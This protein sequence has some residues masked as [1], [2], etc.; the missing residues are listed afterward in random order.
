MT[1]IEDRKPL[2]LVKYATKD[3]Q[4]FFDSLL[5]RLKVEYGDEYN[6]FVTTS[7]GIMLIDLMSYGLSH[8]AWYMDRR[9]SDNY[10]ATARTREA[11]E[12]LTEQIGYKMQ[13]AAASSTDLK[14]VFE[15]GIPADGVMSAGF[16]FAGPNNLIFETTA[17]LLLS[18]S[19]TSVTYYVSV[20]QGVTR[21]LTYTSNGEANQSYTLGS[22]PSDKFL[23][24][25]SVRCWID[26]EEW[27]EVNFLEY[28][29]T[30]Q[31][32]VSYQAVPPIVRFGDGV[33]GNIPPEDSEI[34]LQFVVI[35]GQAGNVKSE[36]ITSA[37]DTL[38]ILGEEVS[39]TVTNEDGSGGGT[40]PESA[41]KARTFAPFSFAAR[42]AA[43]T[44]SD[45]YALSSTFNS[46]QYGRVS[47][48]YAN[49][50]RNAEDDEYLK[51][52]TGVIETLLSNY[53][54]TIE[55]EEEKIVEAVD[56]ITDEIT[57]G[58]TATDGIE[59]IRTDI[60]V[61]QTAVVDTT[62]ISS[63]AEAN[64]IIGDMSNASDVLTEMDA[65]I[66]TITAPP[67]AKTD[68]ENLS[69]QMAS[70]IS[71]ANGKANTI[72]T[73]SDTI[74][75]AALI[76][77]DAT[78]GS[79]NTIESY[80]DDINTVFDNIEAENV[81]LTD[82]ASTIS[83]SA[84][85]LQTNVNNAL[86]DIED[87]FTELFDH[88]CKSNVVQVPILVQTEDGSYVAPS[89]GLIQALQTYLDGIKEVTHVVTVI[90]G[91]ESLVP[92]NVDVSVKVISSYVGSEV[93]S[94]ISTVITSMLT[95][96][97]FDSPLYLSD[98]YTTIDE[99]VEGINYI[100]IVVTNQGSESYI[101]S[102]G[103]LVPPK[104]KIITKGTVDVTEIENG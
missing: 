34:K 6:D 99:N 62:A 72:V 23:A 24:D 1:D 49:V 69:S 63:K 50:L 64:N 68:L 100:N 48:A 85:T 29:K 44:Q 30:N 11:V 55:T 43:I 88:D 8:L 93:I 84:A 13:P 47:K 52:L 4:S 89:T 60:L 45:Y 101:D 74:I 76:I 16:Q 90:D 83:G 56:N 10:L 2:N 17:D 75:G 35:D 27:E 31:F 77:S 15:D 103:N 53:V 19:A 102:D 32:E 81:V 33:A 38:K 61:P 51:F 87:Y 12:P 80:V 7:Q 79:T 46:P 86:Q 58:R 73:Q 104:Q 14:L 28:E 5:R 59:T 41:D 18:F 96:R 3:F 92:A 94:Q 54:S 70:I 21:L 39:F 40:D 91:T 71:S 78:T 57:D 95:G 82:A 22:V 20:K 66:A 26:G 36:T 9:A 42:D 97:D 25:Q 98:L 67:S 37:I 65:E